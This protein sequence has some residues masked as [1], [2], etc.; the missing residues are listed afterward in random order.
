MSIDRYTTKYFVGE[1]IVDD[2]SEIPSPSDV[3][4]SMVPE[5]V[6]ETLVARKL[7][8]AVCPREPNPAELNPFLRID[9]LAPFILEEPQQHDSL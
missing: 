2:F 5:S 4:M 7:P 6:G 8:I 3:S 1:G 9:T